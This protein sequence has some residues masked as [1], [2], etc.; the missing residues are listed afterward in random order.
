[1]H[2]RN[3]SAN[4]ACA[5]PLSEAKA[6]MATTT[7]G[8]FLPLILILPP[9]LG[10]RIENQQAFIALFQISPLIFVF[11]QQIVARLIKTLD[12]HRGLSDSNKAFVAGSYIFAGL[13]SAAAHIYVLIISLF[14]SNTRIAFSRVFLPSHVEIDLRNSNK[15]TEGAHLFL[16][17]DWVIINLTCIIYTYFLLEAHLESLI[18]YLKIPSGLGKV[19]AMPLVMMTTILLG[20]GAAVSFACAAIENGPRKGNTAA[21]M[22]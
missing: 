8:L 11:I 9:V 13:S 14:T 19:V 18:R 4:Q 3:R 21:K 22:K 5:V 10:F 17:Y 1:M 12:K 15:I 20:P 7:F 6:L 2:L 16:Q